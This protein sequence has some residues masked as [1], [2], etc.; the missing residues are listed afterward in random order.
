MEVSV[1]T[2]VRKTPADLDSFPL[3][4]FTWKIAPAFACGN[5]VV[6]KSAEATPLSALYMCQLLKEAGFP[7]GTVNL[8][9][10]YGKT[11]GAA[12][13]SHMDVDKVAFTGSTVTGRAILK[14]AAASNLKKV[15]LELGGKSPVRV[16]FYKRLTPA[17]TFLEH[18]LPRCGHQEGC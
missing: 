10:G 14:A 5:T 7:P 12:I 3:L 17:N 15:T 11:A 9:S 18:Y 13:A 2:L 6:I 1:R 8:I 16:Y 4:M